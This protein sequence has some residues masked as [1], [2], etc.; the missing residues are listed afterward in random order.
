[1]AVLRT[2]DPPEDDNP[3]LECGPEP[4][5]FATQLDWGGAAGALGMIFR[6]EL[7]VSSP[8]GRRD[9]PINWILS[10]ESDDCRLGEDSCSDVKTSCQSL[11]GLVKTGR[12]LGFEEAESG[13]VASVVSFGGG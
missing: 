4:W 7:R 1:M 12:I 13:S 9:Y 6:R 5:N 10:L 2:A 3:R 8:I 11:T